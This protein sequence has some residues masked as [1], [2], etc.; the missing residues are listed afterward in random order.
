MQMT[1]EQK[2]KRDPAVILRRAM[3][4]LRKRWDGA[5]GMNGR[6]NILIL[7]QAVLR[8]EQARLNALIRD[9]LKTEDANDR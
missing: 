2:L 4:Q 5:Q 6:A 1:D 7:K 8:V 9:L 3:T